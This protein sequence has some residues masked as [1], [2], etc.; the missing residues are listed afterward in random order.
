M[1]GM[2]WL[3]LA[4]ICRASATFPLV[5]S[6]LGRPPLRP[7]A[8]AAANPALVRSRMRSRS[9]SGKCSHHV[10]DQLATWR[11]GINLLS[12]AHK[13]DAALFEILE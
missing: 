3:L 4:N 9:N 6:F 12:Q 1:S 10:K 11:C 5:L 7:L 8:L 2:E 13:L